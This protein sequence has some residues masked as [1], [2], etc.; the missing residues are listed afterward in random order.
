MRYFIDLRSVLLGTLLVLVSAS[1]ALSEDI[2]TSDIDTE[3]GARVFT[4]HCSHCH[5][6]KGIGGAGPNL[7]DDVSVHGEQMLQILFTIMNG[8]KDK[9]MQG[10]RG[11]LTMPEIEQVAAYVHSLHDTS[12][13]EKATSSYGYMF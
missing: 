4:T 12:T 6:I 7:T 10:W 3:A 2:D 8:V 5:G 1:G 11:R 9:P 13:G